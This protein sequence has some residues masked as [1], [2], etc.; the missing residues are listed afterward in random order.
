[1]THQ[2]TCVVRTYSSKVLNGASEYEHEIAAALA[3]TLPTKAWEADPNSPRILRFK[4]L[5]F[6]AQNMGGER[7]RADLLVTGGELYACGLDLNAYGKK[8]LILH[9]LDPRDAPNQWLQRQVK[10]RVLSALPKFDRVVVVA[11]YWK[12]QLQEHM[13]P[14]KIAVIRSSFDRQEMLDMVSGDAVSSIRQALGLPLDRRVIYA[15]AALALKGAP[16]VI[17]KLRGSDCVVVT[18][19]RG[20]GI[21]G[22]VHFDLPR[23]AYL[24]LLSACDAA[25]F[26]PSFLEGWVRSAHESLLLGVPVI[27]YA[28]GGL[29]ELLTMTGQVTYDD[30]DDLSRCIEK[31][32]TE[33][34]DLIAK[35]QNALRPFDRAY[36]K[37]AWREIVRSCGLALT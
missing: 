2:P 5:R 18:S 3:A 33:R 37:G 24:K 13:D 15:G 30:Q 27:G 7:P 28:Q 11:D 10:R 21:Q 6:L 34:H 12:Q 4:K 8:V 17:A 32:V 31:A 16:A 35:A 29:G 25:V 14:A 23:A 36:F 22:A 9:H 26:L 20:N 19:G 1:M